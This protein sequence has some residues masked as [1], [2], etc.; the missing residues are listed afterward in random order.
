MYITH[1]HVIYNTA[2]NN[3]RMHIL[4]NAQI[5]L[6]IFWMKTSHKIESQ[7]IESILTTV[8]KKKKKRAKHPTARIQT[9]HKGALCRGRDYQ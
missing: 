9:Q 5:S 4:P 3:Y 8:K 1:C 6:T 2:A 7:K